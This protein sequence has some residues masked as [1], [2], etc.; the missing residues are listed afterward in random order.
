MSRKLI[1]KA[2]TLITVLSIVSKLLAYVRVS[3]MTGYYGTGVEADA[4]TFAFT[5]QEFL[6][7]LIAGGTLVSAIIP[8][9][10]A[11]VVAGDRNRLVRFG[12]TLFNATSLVLLAVVV[13]WY[14]AGPEILGGLTA[15]F[16]GMVIHSSRT[17]AMTIHLGNIMFP[18]ILFFGLVS[19]GTAILNSFQHFLAPAAA[20][21]ILNLVMVACLVGLHPSLGV[22]SMA[23]GVLLGT[24]IQVAIM[25][26]AL[27]NRLGSYSCLV[28][29]RDEHLG[30]VWR[31]LKPLLWGLVTYRFIY[32]VN[33]FFAINLGQGEIAALG[34][35]EFLVLS[36]VDIVGLS[37]ATA[38]YP[39]LAEH[40]GQNRRREYLA[41][42]VS[43]LRITAIL[44]IPVTGVLM[45]FRVPLIALLYQHGHF[46]AE[47]TRMTAAILLF[48]APAAL[49]Q[50]F[51]YLMK[52]VYYAGRSM[53]LPTVIAIA[54]LLL[55]FILMVVLVGPMGTRGI[56][57]SMTVA[58]GV[59]A[60]AMLIALRWLHRDF[61]LFDF[62]GFCGFVLL[63]AVGSLLA[64]RWIFSLAATWL[65]GS[66]LYQ[67]FAP[68][69]LALIGFTAIFLLV[70]WWA[71]IDE[72]QRILQLI[73][74]KR[75]AES[76]TPA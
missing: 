23:V 40:A 33:K 8:V 51:N 26:P 15:F 55:N 30:E 29:D 31:M 24:I 74:R 20:P 41:T 22:Q 13:G 14:T 70:C 39:T 10:R 62:A 42:T 2:A 49:F 17:L 45:V 52:N 3:L 25:V 56:A 27:K 7:H 64:S 44:A 4:F 11:L 43:F 69:G 72:L 75:A 59:Q 37:V 35:A 71:R 21:A 68:L 58:Y 65:P 19:I 36:F 9:Y 32:I 54:S 46:Q 73:R 47:S 50:C 48:L 60:G 5:I 63:T 16:P 12:S 34:Y 6:R 53:V 57:L 18:S 61:P 28:L 76:T 38:V 67:R 1:L 66:I